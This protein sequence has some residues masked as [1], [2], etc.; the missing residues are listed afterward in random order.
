[1]TTPPCGSQWVL[2]SYTTRKTI[3]RSGHGTLVWWGSG[4]NRVSECKLLWFRLSLPTLRATANLRN[5][6]DIW[7][8]L[9][10][11][12]PIS[13]RNHPGVFQGKHTAIHFLHVTLLRTRDALT[14]DVA[15]TTRRRHQET[16]G[17]DRT[18]RIADIARAQI[19]NVQAKVNLWKLPSEINQKIVVDAAGASPASMDIPDPCPLRPRL[20]R[21]EIGWTS[22]KTANE[23]VSHESAPLRTHS[24][25]SVPRI[26]VERKI[27]EHSF[28][29][30]CVPFI[31]DEGGTR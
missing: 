29:L 13:K 15:Q 30:K 20:F 23:E 31:D 25:Q 8:M 26:R 10:S 14:V 7:E 19:P 9:T 24:M 11:H 17:K 1:M 27:A 2:D 21:L 18:H 5:R 28:S 16:H 4:S 3:G 6:Q 12:A 22:N